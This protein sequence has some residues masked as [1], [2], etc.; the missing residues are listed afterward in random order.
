MN[1]Q[2]LAAIAT[3]V[4]VGGCAYD[5]PFADAIPQPSNDCV[6]SASQYGPSCTADNWMAERDQQAA[7]YYGEHLQTQASSATAS[8]PP[9]QPAPTALAPAAQPPS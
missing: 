1:V 7:K 2:L 3:V 5:P 8:V 9:T 4:V 6:E